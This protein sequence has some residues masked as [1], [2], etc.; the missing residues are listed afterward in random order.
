MEKIRLSFTGD[1][2][3][4]PEQ[5]KALG[6]KRGFGDI[7]YGIKSIFENSD[8]VIGNLETPLAGQSLKYTYEKWSFN[9][10]ETLLYALKDLGFNLLSTANNHCL[11]RGKEGLLNTLL[12]LDRFGID[13]IGTYV[14]QKD[15]DLSYI[16]TIGELRIA[17]LAYTYGTNSFFNQEYLEEDGYMVNLFQPQKNKVINKNDYFHRIINKL[18]QIISS[19]IPYKWRFY[20]NL[21][22]LKN[23]IKQSKEKADFVVMCMHCGGQYNAVPDKYTLFLVDYLLDNGVNFVIGNHPHVVHK[24][25]KKGNQNF[26]FYSL[27]DLCSYPGSEGSCCDDASI[28]SSYSIIVHIDFQNQKLDSVSCKFEIVKSII[29]NQGLSQVFSLYDLILHEENIEKKNELL[30]DNEWIVRKVLD[31]QQIKVDLKREYSL[32]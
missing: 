4:E 9:T 1:I 27:G 30:V 29:D 18:F 19:F 17:F 21:K 16:R 7:F 3:I 24:S 2:I 6:S 31:S 12:A 14:T 25:K 13:H 10:P 28:R 15:R 5:L 20:S 23:D 22:Q 11:D 8:M 26:A 32:F